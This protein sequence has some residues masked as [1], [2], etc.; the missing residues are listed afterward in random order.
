MDDTVKLGY[1][2]SANVSFQGELDTGFIRE[3]WNEMEDDEK[4]GVISE[5]IFELVDVWEIEE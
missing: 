4:G 2:S 3:E 5:I 1:S